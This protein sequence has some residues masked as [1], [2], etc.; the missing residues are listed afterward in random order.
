MVAGTNV[1]AQDIAYVTGDWVVSMYLW[2]VGVALWLL[3]AYAFFTVITVGEQKPP[4]DQGMSGNWLLAVVA[5]ESVAV[6]RTVVAPQSTAF[7]SGLTV[8]EVLFAALAMYLVGGMLYLMIITLIFYR[9][10]FFRLAAAEMAPSYWIN[11]GAVAITALTGASLVLDGPKWPLLTQLAPFLE[12][13]TLFFWATATWWIP[14]LFL[15]GVWRH[16]HKRFP[17]R[18]DP[19][20]WG[21]VFPLGMYS[22]ATFQL[23]KALGLPAL[24]RIPA[25]FAHIALGAWVLVFTGM[26]AE[27]FRPSV[28][29]PKSI[30]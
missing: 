5:T 2:L 21:I 17:L 22:A 16:V 6:T 27:W 24:E 10:S 18:Y 11:M 12:G 8:P 19:Q 3:F 7:I 14:L 4:L 20:M 26:V 23:A 13:F 29:A 9:F 1:L 15:L 30:V 28:A 25:G